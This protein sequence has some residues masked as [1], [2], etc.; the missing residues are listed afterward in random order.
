MDEK[1]MRLMGDDAIGADAEAIVGVLLVG[2]DP[3][4]RVGPPAELGERVG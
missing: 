3:A 2:C 1:A 4:A